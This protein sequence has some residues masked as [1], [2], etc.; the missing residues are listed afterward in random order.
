M[1]QLRKRSQL[2]G[3]MSIV[4]AIVAGA[5]LPVI[6]N[7]GGT[8]PSFTLTRASVAA[9]STPQVSGSEAPVANASLPCTPKMK[10]RPDTGLLDGQSITVSGSG[11]PPNDFIPLIE[12]QSGATQIS[13]C[14]YEEFEGLAQT[15]QTGAFSTSLNV[16]RLLETGTTSIDCAQRKACEIAA[17]NDEG[18]GIEAATPITFKDVPLPTLAVTP[19]T[20][21]ADG[22]DVTVTGANFDPGSTV[23]FTECPVGQAGYFYDCDSDATGQAVA[24]PSGTFTTT[25]SVARILTTD[26]G[27]EGGTVDCAVAPG[28]DLAAFGGFDE[29]FQALAPLSFNP[30]IAPLPPLDLTMTLKPKGQVD[31][32]GGAVLSATLSCTAKQPVDVSVDVSLSETA[33][34]ELADSEITTEETCDKTPAPETLTLPDQTVPFSAGVGEVTLEIYARDGSAVTQQI[35][36]GSVALSVP[37]HQPP[38]VY[39]VALGD[40]LAAGYASPSG[41]GYVNDLLADLLKTS[42]DLQLVDLGCSGE[43]TTSFIEDDFCG[44]PAGSQLAAATAFLAAHRGSVALVTIDIGGNDYLGCLDA[45]PPSYNAKCIQT[46]GELV[47]TNLT[48][49]MSQLHAAAGSSV[50]FLGM[51]YFDPFLDYWPDGSTGRTVAKESVPVVG[52]VNSLLSSVYTAA[53]APVA[54]VEGAFETTDLHTKVKTSFGLVPVAVDNTCMWLD[55]TCAKGQGGFGDDTVA[56]GSAVIAGAFEK[57]LPADLS[58]PAQR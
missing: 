56:A 12:C 26:E 39:Y 13:Q 54:D 31:V 44:Y 52:T 1:E 8:A 43:T 55:Y 10:A 53:Q 42:P 18:D 46:T 49:I 21:L 58:E 15:D 51:N 16:A 36:S 11:F 5:A 40:S 24:G 20:D 35:L 23:T 37:A 32:S 19:A 28:C 4:A 17:S 25:Y 33:D 29:D 2:I 48:L 6:L 22:Q 27:L 41:Q 14:Q 38:P 3:A 7:A 34:S 57:V 9:C 30:S 47:K 45:D 50:P